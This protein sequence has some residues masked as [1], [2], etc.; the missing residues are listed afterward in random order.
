MGDLSPLDQSC[1]RS[2]YPRMGRYHRTHSAYRI[3]VPFERKIMKDFYM[4][5]ENRRFLASWILGISFAMMMLCYIIDW[6]GILQISGTF[7][8][9]LVT[10]WAWGEVIAAYRIRKTEQKLDNSCDTPFSQCLDCERH[11]LCDRYGRHM[12]DHSN[13]RRG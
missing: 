3:C 7:G 12:D 11:N 4:C 13:E 2:V 5:A 1:H 8:C 9:F 6:H 10:A